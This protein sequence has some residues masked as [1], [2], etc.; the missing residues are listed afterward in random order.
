MLGG[1]RDARDEVKVKVDA[2][3]NNVEKIKQTVTDWQKESGFHH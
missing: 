2:A 1:S 3:E